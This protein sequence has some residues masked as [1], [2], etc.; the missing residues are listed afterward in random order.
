MSDGDVARPRWRDALVLTLLA[1]VIAGGLVHYGRDV[2]A[3]RRTDTARPTSGTSAV[4][5]PA[6][7]AS[8]APAP[9]PSAEETAELESAPPTDPAS[10]P[11]APARGGT[12]W[13]GRAAASLR[14][15]GLPDG[16]RGLEW[17][18]PTFAEQR[19]DCSRAARNPDSYPVRLSYEC[20]LRIAG[21]SVT[22]V[23]DQVDDPAATERWLLSRLGRDAMREL[24]GVGQHGGRCLFSDGR[25]TPARV[26]TAYEHFP[27]VVSVYADN[28]RVARAAWADLVRMRAEDK[29]RGLRA[30]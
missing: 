14:L 29:I 25:N 28:M 22:V 8:S 13:D 9:S 23:Y 11:P 16:A 21:Q 24:P 26:T 15:C 12:C 17:V 4:R 30:S 1:V 5:S 18:F 7:S 20:F 27:Y 10:P 3:D 6:P 2:L 19:F